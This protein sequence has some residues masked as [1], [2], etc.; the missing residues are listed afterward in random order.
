MLGG[1][2][3]SPKGVLEQKVRS[4]PIKELA[5]QTGVDRNTVRRFKR[6]ERVQAKTRFRL[7]KAASNWKK[8]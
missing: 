3:T 8:V 4:I 5:R 1:D 2:D 6:G 7:L